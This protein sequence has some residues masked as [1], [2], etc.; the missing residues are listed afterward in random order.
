MATGEFSLKA[1]NGKLVRVKAVIGRT[2]E[3]VQITGDFFLHP[4]ESIIAIES[5]LS[6]QP[7]NETESFFEEK[8]SS[9]LSDSNAILHGISAHDIAL[10]LKGAIA[11]AR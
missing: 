2:V 4:E 1:K 10:A 7:L 6:G 5:A 3:S 9:V 8:V 11:N